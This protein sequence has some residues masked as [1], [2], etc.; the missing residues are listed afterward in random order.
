MSSQPQQIVPKLRNN[1]NILRDDQ[2]SYGDPI[3][4]R[5]FL[6]FLKMA[7]ERTRLPYPKPSRVPSQP[8]PTPGAQHAAPFPGP[9]VRFVPSVSRARTAR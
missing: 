4:Q 5:T 7:D 1:W 9:H 2:F 3:E 6:L 8:A